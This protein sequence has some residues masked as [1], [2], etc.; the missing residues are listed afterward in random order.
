MSSRLQRLVELRKQDPLIQRMIVGLHI[1]GPFINEIDGY[2][3]ATRRC[4][5]SRLLDG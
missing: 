5:S 3:G 2:R 1:E 4:G